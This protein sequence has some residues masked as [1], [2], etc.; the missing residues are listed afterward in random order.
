MPVEP[1]YG[2][3]GLKTYGRLIDS[4]FEQF[5]RY[6]FLVII[7]IC[8]VTRG[9]I[10]MEDPSQRMPTKYLSFSYSLS[11]KEYIYSAKYWLLTGD[12]ISL[13]IPRDTQ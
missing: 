13:L 12:I 9:V 4:N 2:P 8:L 7:E 10:L 6:D 5:H 11:F 1:K 3:L